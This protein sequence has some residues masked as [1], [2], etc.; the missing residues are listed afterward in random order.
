MPQNQTQPLLRRPRLVIL[1]PLLLFFLWFWT[2]SL[3]SSPPPPMASSSLDSDSNTTPSN[4][5][6]MALPVIPP[7]KAN[8]ELVYES[9][10]CIRIYK[11][12]LVERYFGSE[13]TP[14]S[15][16]PTTGVT[17]K[18][19]VI[20]SRIGVG[21]RLYLPKLSDESK[22]IPILVYYHGGGF[23]LGSAYNPTFHNYFNGFVA[24]SNVLVVSVEY[25]LAP[26]HPVPA[27]YED[28]WLALDWVVSHADGAGQEPWINKHADFD[29]LYLGGES[30][31]ANIAHHIAMKVG[32]SGL[33]KP[34][35]INGLAMI[36]PY[37]LGSNKVESDSID[38]AASESLAS[39][40]KVVN[41]TTTGIDDPFINPFVAGAPKLD[42]LASSRVLV[43]VAGKDTLR[44]RGKLYYNKLKESGWNGEL[45]LREAPGVG[46]TFHL[47]FPT[48]EE[49]VAQDRAISAFLNY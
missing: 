4:S 41:P 26:E 40:W 32:S 23:C 34:V 44:D 29:R 21:A 45:E 38:P 9:L 36:H 22:K 25:R 19:V 1:L 14:A 47:L 10:P 27:Q 48:S 31:G 43:C 42:G 8:E 15:T 13:F 20:D 24:L 11:S 7:A 35:K 5:S 17:S 6:A 49:A 33:G 3:F 16:D 2:T 30:A 12:G 18:D 46:H 39:L 28:S 37:Y